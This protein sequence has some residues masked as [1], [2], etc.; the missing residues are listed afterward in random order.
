MIYSLNVTDSLEK[1][2]SSCFGF[3]SA[4]CV[5]SSVLISPSAACCVSA[6]LSCADE[7]FLSA[8]SR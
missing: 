5:S 8:E 4:G 2:P 6:L 7:A 1:F 3:F